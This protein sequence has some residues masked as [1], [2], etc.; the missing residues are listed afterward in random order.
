MT[1]VHALHKT[2]GR[3]C[4]GRG[5]GKTHAHLELLIGHLETSQYNKETND[6][7]DFYYISLNRGWREHAFRL[8]LR[9]LDSKGIVFKRL[10]KWSVKTMNRRVLF[11][12]IKQMSRG[13]NNARPIL[14]SYIE[15]DVD[16]YHFKEQGNEEPVRLIGNGFAR[17]LWERAKHPPEGDPY[18][19]PWWKGNENIIDWSEI[20]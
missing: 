14:K 17:T 19:E 10:N 3:E 8:F 5:V 7:R 18:G 12:T 2:I 16:Y 13:M 11:E 6:I 1:N 15:V 20:R 9:L 4:K